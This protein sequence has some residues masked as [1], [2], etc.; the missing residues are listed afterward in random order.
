MLPVIVSIIL[1]N[2]FGS[3]NNTTTVQTQRIIKFFLYVFIFT[4]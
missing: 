2:F 4:L 1:Y 3:Q